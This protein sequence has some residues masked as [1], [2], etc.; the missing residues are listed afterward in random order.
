LF[1]SIE[2]AGELVRRITAD[3]ASILRD[4]PSA[5]FG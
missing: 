5:V 4:R 2:P 3:A 1:H